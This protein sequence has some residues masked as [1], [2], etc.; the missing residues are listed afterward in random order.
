MKQI[1]W[2]E[3]DGEHWCFLQT[4]AAD[5]K[6]AARKWTDVAVAKQELQ[7]PFWG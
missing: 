5:T 7:E 4:I 6:R 3:M 1:A 2:L